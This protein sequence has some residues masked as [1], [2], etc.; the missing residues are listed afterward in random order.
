MTT[1]ELETE[2]TQK[3]SRVAKKWEL[4]RLEREK[5]SPNKQ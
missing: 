2:M 3:K 5:R 4:G 1:Q